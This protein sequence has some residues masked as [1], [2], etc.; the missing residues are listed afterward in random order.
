MV[1]WPFGLIAVYGALLWVARK[2][3]IFNQPTP[4]STAT[5][6]LYREY[7]A[8]YFWWEL[9]EMGRRV[10]LVGFMVLVSPGS[11]M[12]LIIGAVLSLS[13]L[14][15]QTQAA[16]FKDTGDDFLAN[17]ASF[18]LVIT[19]LCCIAFKVATL[20]ETT[21]LQELMSLEQRE[22]F[23]IYVGLLSVILLISV[24]GTLVLSF[25]MLFVQLA[26]ERAL[27]LREAAMLRLPTT[28]SWRLA[29][30]QRFVC[31]LSHARPRTALQ[32]STH[33]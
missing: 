27:M 9:C 11:V 18:S 5:R 7:E 22:D 20:S 19:F 3:I 23:R 17:S 21:E 1:I 16:P 10:V 26:R 25:S 32:L 15:L 31:F 14:L 33:A 2:A 24:L 12:Q 13:Y 4:L 28:S 29:K 30:G 8:P 6:F